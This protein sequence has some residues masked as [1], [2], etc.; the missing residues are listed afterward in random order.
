MI[1]DKIFGEEFDASITE[2]TPKTK[3]RIL[4]KKHKQSSFSTYRG[5]VITTKGRHYFVKDLDSPN[6]RIVKCVI[7]GS[8]EVEH[9]HKSL[10]TVGDRCSFVVPSLD[11]DGAE[12]GRIIKVYSR[13]T[14]L[15]RKAINSNR[16]DVIASNMDSVLILLAAN[17]PP[18]N[19][20]MLDKI[21]VAC[22]YGEVEPII[23]VNKMD[24]ADRNIVYNDFEVYQ[25]LG[26]HVFFISA[27]N[28]EGLAQLIEIL[29]NRETL[30]IG[31]SGVGKSTLVNKIFGRDIQKIGD[32]AKNL[33]GKHTTTSCYYINLNET[34][35]IIDSPGFREFELFGISK[36]ELPF[37]F[38]DFEPYFQKCKFQPCSHTHE[39]GCE[40]KKALK[41][42]KIDS[43]RY[44]SYIAILE[45]LS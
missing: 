42:G 35:A 26:Y 30:F 20:R 1:V 43:R 36:D 9:P 2:G 8:I 23:C 41:K 21:L 25:K 44:F 39:P 22:E 33:R 6:D 13:N 11:T 14:F 5:L 17:N 38:R 37:Y 40:V 4:V 27:L 24:L 28:T 12:L 19:L 7:S 32:M 29:Q 16:E 18:Y 45:N 15:M 34:T 3:K 10:V 31:V